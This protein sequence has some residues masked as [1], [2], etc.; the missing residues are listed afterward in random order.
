MH[1]VSVEIWNEKSSPLLLE[2]Y[3]RTAAISPQFRKNLCLIK[4]TN[5]NGVV[6][7]T[8]NQYEYNEYHYDFYKEDS[9]SVSKL[10]LIE[11]IPLIVA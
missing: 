7:H 4:F 6:K 3:H 5:D 10:N 2:K 9:F 11:M 8:P 1:G